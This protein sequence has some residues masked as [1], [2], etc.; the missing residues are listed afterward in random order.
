MENR[1]VIR[2]VT[3]GREVSVAET[4]FRLN[5]TTNTLIF[6]SRYASIQLFGRTLPPTP[7]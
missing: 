3:E 4:F 5:F 6:F 1:I 7:W 2:I